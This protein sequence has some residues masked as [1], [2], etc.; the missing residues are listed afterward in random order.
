M[1]REL[2]N[3]KYLHEL[4]DVAQDQEEGD[5]ISQMYGRLV[6]SR[7]SFFAQVAGLLQTDLPQLQFDLHKLKNQFGNLGCEAVSNLL[8]EMYQLAKGQKTNELQALLPNLR[9][10]S[11]ETLE[12]LQRVLIH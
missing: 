6:E 4:L 11:D 2:I 8:E 5:L 10:L 3:Q 7:D 1:E 12:K 9:Q